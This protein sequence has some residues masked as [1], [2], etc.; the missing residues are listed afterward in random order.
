MRKTLVQLVAQNLQKAYEASAFTS[1]RQLAIASGVV[2]NTVKHLFKPD[3]RAPG[4]RGETSPRLDSLDKLAN[5]M[6][7]EGWQLMQENFDPANRPARV[8]TAREAD[9]YAK[10]EELYRQLPPGPDS[11][12]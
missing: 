1:H 7:Y 8:L 9:W 4:P 2:P 6:G 12:Q 5:A 10:I 11:A 3:S